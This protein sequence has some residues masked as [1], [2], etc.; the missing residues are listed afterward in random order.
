MSWLSDPAQRILSGALDGLSRRQSLI[1]GNL[2]NIDTP[3]FQPSAIDFESVLQA[4]LREGTAEAAAGPQN[5]P[6]A[7]VRMLATDPRHLQAN[8]TGAPTGAVSEFE[9]TIRND[10]NTVDID[11][12]MLALADTQM[13]YS[14]V[15]RLL[16]GR[17]QMLNDAI[18]RGR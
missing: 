9:G 5:G 15:A 10:G 2:A 6:N 12:E 17:H 7:A 18:G 16:G 8:G 14:A 4:H 11:S 13:R 1:S 3:G